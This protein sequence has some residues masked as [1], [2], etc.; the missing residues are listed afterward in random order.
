MV[1]QPTRNTEWVQVKIRHQLKRQ[2]W[3]QHHTRTSSPQTR[4]HHYPGTNSWAWSTRLM[5]VPVRRAPYPLLSKDLALVLLRWVSWRKRVLIKR[6][7][8]HHLRRN[9]SIRIHLICHTSNRELADPLIVARTTLWISIWSN[10]PMPSNLWSP[11]R[12]LR[13]LLPNKILQ[14]IWAKLLWTT[15]QMETLQLFQITCPTRS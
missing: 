3:L 4:C 14:S 12:K 1:D 11:L 2:Q 9:P 13:L 7:I 15:L 10:Q 8:I 6:L 5:V